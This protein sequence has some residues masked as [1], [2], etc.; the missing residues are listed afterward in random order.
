MRANSPAYFFKLQNKLFL[1][2][3]LVVSNS[4][5]RDRCH[6]FNSKNLTISCFR[7]YCFMAGQE[8][9][10]KR[11]PTDEEM[12]VAVFFWIFAIPCGLFILMAIFSLIL[13]LLGFGSNYSSSWYR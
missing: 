10:M 11:K 6:F 7:L 13:A 5:F 2:V 9:A 1:S 12:I 8:N 4:Q 3:V